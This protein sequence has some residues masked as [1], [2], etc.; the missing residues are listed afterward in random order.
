[1]SVRNVGGRIDFAGRNAL[2][3]PQECHP[4]A[5]RSTACV[6]SVTHAEIRRGRLDPGGPASPNQAQPQYIRLAFSATRFGAPRSQR[7]V[8]LVRTV[9]DFHLPYLVCTW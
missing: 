8:P 5:S 6:D 1:M 4:S 7:M 9:H 3:L 2:L